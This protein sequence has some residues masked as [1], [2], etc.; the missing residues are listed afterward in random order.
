[1]PAETPFT[2]NEIVTQPAAWAE[3]VTVVRAQAGALKALRLADY[4]QLL[5][6][7]C[8]STYYLALAA[9]AL[10]QSLTGHIARAL[11][12]SELLL[13]P[14]GAYPG[15][16]GVSLLISVSRSG[17]TT[18]TLRA[19]EAFRR[20]RRGQVITV[21]NYP[22]APLASMG[23][24]NLVIP[25][26]REASVAQTRSFAS[27]YVACVALAAVLAGDE[28]Q[29]NAL[30]G[31]QPVGER[32]LR[33]YA[34]LAQE[35]GA[36]DRLDQ[37]FFLGSG[38]RYGLA[39]E[40]SLKMKEMTLSVSEPFHFLEFRHGPMSMITPQTAVVG[41]LSEAARKHEE[42]VLHQMRELGGRI[43]SLAESGADVAFHSG[44]PETARGVLYL[45]VLQLMAYY[46][47]VKRGLDP[48]RPHNLSKVI[49]LDL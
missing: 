11:P 37:F 48:D 32:L 27:M 10:T 4:R 3:A 26:G 8:G 41:L 43:L 2:Y 30:A 16:G 9:A 45:P 18:E 19:V 7:G 44:L 49:E 33:D 28:V 17:T 23:D 24:L 42:A 25:A 35:W 39:C 20:Q 13:Y 31:L 22:E 15:A 34:G 36:D 29:L 46:R 6:T 40:A 12:A 5:F 21:S 1:M 38:P 47:A 14:D